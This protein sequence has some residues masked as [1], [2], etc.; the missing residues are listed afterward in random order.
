M[1][2]AA[3]L[4]KSPFA[5]LCLFDLRRGMGR[6]AI[7]AG[8]MALVDLYILVRFWDQPLIAAPFLFLPLFS[9]PA[10]SILFGFD[11]LRN[12]WKEQTHYLLL[13]LPARGR[14]LLGAKVLAVGVQLLMLA[15][16]AAGVAWWNLGYRTSF[17]FA[18]ADWR[19]AE[20]AALFPLWVK[21]LGA[22]F[23]F[24]PLLNLSVASLLAFLAGQT[25][26]RGRWFPMGLISLAVLWVSV[27]TG[28]AAE[29]W[30]VFWD[31]IWSLFQ[32][33]PDIDLKP[34]IAAPPIGAQTCDSP[35]M[36][37]VLHL[38]WLALQIFLLTVLLLIAAALWDRK[39]EV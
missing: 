30:R 36:P 6:L 12:E 33:M 23:A 28:V 34:Y 7:A 15:V 14:T 37:C 26:G 24:L 5:T 4:R 39:A 29:V 2:T 25:V 17:P 18:P 11:A 1:K 10:L 3:A 31:V 38:G 35:E 19:L 8:L 16:L 20:V 21:T 22:A 13:S 27:S 9:L 32:W